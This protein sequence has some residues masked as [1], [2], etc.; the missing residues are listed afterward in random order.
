MQY[1]DEQ[2]PAEGPSRRLAVRGP[3]ELQQALGFLRGFPPAGAEEQGGEYLAAHAINGRA[4]LVR[5]R[6]H[7]DGGLELG[8]LGY[9]L[10]DDDLD[11]AERLAR[12][13]FS[14]DWDGD[15][16]LALGEQDAV[17]ASVQRRFR[18]L[19]PV[20]FGSPFEALCWAI[21]SQ[22]VTLAQAARL[23]ARLGAVYGPTVELDGDEYQAF[24]A[25]EHLLELSAALDA[26]ILRVPAVK[27]ERLAALAQRAAAGD[28]EAER[29]LGMP[30][31]EARA[32]L[33][34]SPGIG[35][36]ASEF[37]LIRG[38]GHPDLL[39]S[40]E[41]RLLQSVQ[42]QYGLDAPPSLEAL[43]QL[44]AGWIPFRSWAAFLLRVALEADRQAPTEEPA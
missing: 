18:G 7:P 4:L 25:P 44:S 41:A 24:P 5:L 22:R 9:D 23:K 34:Q 32:W 10:T 8:V 12:R 21:L 31:D 1:D 37:A 19:R 42:R 40:Q 39:P 29:L 26:D 38:A 6:D 3:F 15:A 16:F 17:L 28:F 30:L 20:L 13:V 2:A 35:P 27:L 33:E 36:W 11:A 14:L 43:E